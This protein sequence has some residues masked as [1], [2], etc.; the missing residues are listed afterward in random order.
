MMLTR[1]C[2]ASCIVLALLALTTLPALADDHATRGQGGQRRP[3]IG[4]AFGGGSA[5]GLAHVGVVRWLEEHRIPIDLIAGTSM[6]GLIGGAVASG[7]S[8]DELTALLEQVN[9]DEMFG[10]LPFRYKNVRRKEDAR[11]Y[12]SRIEFGIKR[13]IALPIA[14]NSGQQV[15]FLLARIA[16]PYATVASFDELPTPFRAIAVDLVTAQQVV[17]DRGSLASALRATMSL[18]GIF[19]P[20]ERD[21]QVLVDG[22]AMNNVPADVVR[23]MGADMVI[24]VNVGFMGD[25]RAVSRSLLGLMSETVDVMMQAS[26]RASMKSADLIINPPLD[27]FASLDWRRSPELAVEGYRAA[28]AMK[29]QLLPF[30]VGDDEWAAYLESRRGRRKATWPVPQFVSVTGAVPSDR[31]HMEAVLAPLVGQKTL[32]VQI[33]EAKLEILAGL[34]R[35]ETVGWQLEER[36]GR[37]GLLVEARPKSH[38][39]PFLMLGLNLQNTTSDDFTFQLAARYLTFD[40]AGSGSEL[41]VDGAVGALPGIGAELYRPFGRTPLFLAST[42][43]V[44]RGTLSF[45]S[46]DVVVARYREDRAGVGLHVGTNLGRD[47][48]VRFGI[49]VGNLSA[50]VDTGDPGLP[51]LDGRETRARLAWRYDGQDSPVAPSTGVRAIATFDRIVASPDAPPDFATDRSNDDIAQV[52]LRSS[53]FRSVRRR[54]RIFL[55][56]GFGSTWGHPLATEQFQLGAPLRLGAYNVGHFRGDHYGVLTAGYLHTIGRLPDFLGGSIYIGSWLENGSA[57]DDVD[58]ATFRTNLSLGALA[59]TLVGPVLLG[60]SFDFRGASRFYIGIGRLF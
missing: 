29:D 30:A 39:P 53:I 49:A 34:D 23:R 42:A 12:P 22:G 14:L 35:Y 19:P 2:P 54:D 18:P 52:E 37:P 60:G 17:L 59:D 21:G 36:E 50:H 45:V 15:D 41:R 27:G 9:W 58:D 16:G 33:L 47:S 10:F 5:R 4:V 31:V 46:D 55:A 25:T 1:R 26:A 38:A 28:E 24:A 3:R 6:G 40:A 51:Q 56:G 32:D 57:F 43:A 8:A 11:A 7:M 20:V 13:G 48:D 44:Q